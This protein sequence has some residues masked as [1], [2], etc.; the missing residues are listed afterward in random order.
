MWPDNETMEDLLG[1]QVHADLIRRLMLDPK[2]LPVTVGVFGDWGGGKTSIM[3]MLE[4][5]LD[6]DHWPVGSPERAAHEGVA[7]VY[8][9]AWLFEGYDDAKAAL[10]SAVLLQLGEHKRFGP[11]VR[12]KV[13]SL[14]KS[15]DVMRVLR[16]GF[17]HV[18]VPAAA[19][20]LTGGAAAVPAGLAAGVGLGVLAG[21]E[22]DGKGDTNTAGLDEG[23]DWS[24]LIRHDNTPNQPLDVR[25]FR[26]R[27]AKMLADSN[28]RSL[29]VLIDDLD[30]CTPERIIESLEAVKLF[31]SVDRTAFVVGADPRIVQHAIRSRYARVATEGEG[32]DESDRLVKDYLEKVVQVPYRLPRLSASEIETYMGLLFCQ[33]HLTSAEATVCVRTCAQERA[34]NRYG[35]F[36][37]TAVKAALTRADLGPALSGALTLCAS[38]A[39]LMADGLKG[40]PR[41]VK[42][43]LNA[44]LLRKELASVAQ[45]A[46]VRDDV[47]V[48]LM[49]LEYTDEERF[50]E[51]FGWQARQNGHSDEL[52]KLEAALVGPDGRADNEEGAKAV[53]PQWATST[54]RRWVA[55]PPVLTGMDLRDYFWV[56]RDRLESTFTGLSLV[57]P[58]VRVVLDGLVSGNAGKRNAAIAT[59]KSLGADER[60]SLL[61]LVDQLVARQ[62]DQKSGYEALRVLAEGRVSGAA[63]LLGDILEKRPAESVPPS[64]GADLVTLS[65]SLPEPVSALQAAISR[66][67]KSGARIGVAVKDALKGGR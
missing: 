8:V 41:Q 25:T 65:R 31:L 43:F 38:A 22:K 27:F 59:A 57:P 28:I 14:L 53:S 2:M 23:V 60:A 54:M 21:K 45:L 35:T 12:D 51:L 42:R 20:Y 48:K 46:N 55:M 49:I 67:E 5:D 33:R 63:D 44:L 40:N 18:A 62:P 29:V 37:Y 3:K 52:A 56:A 26:E 4:R 17:K 61:T 9:N 30:R 1:F 13:V 36:G 19:A 32:R 66:L 64:V 34:K 15:I 10:L 16:L 39:P 11:K 58:V 7:V 50:L 24:E 47:L 6:M